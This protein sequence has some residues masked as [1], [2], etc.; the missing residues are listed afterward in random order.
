MKTLRAFAWWGTRGDVMREMAAWMARLAVRGGVSATRLPG[1]RIYK[2]SRDVPRAPLLYEQGIIIVGQGAKR[3]FLGDTVYEYNPDRYL[4]LSVPLPVEC[5]TSASPEEP[6]LALLVDIDLGV[7]KSL[8]EALEEHGDLVPG[9]QGASPGLF[10]AHADLSF[11]QTVCRLLETLQSPLDTE[12]LG[13]G[14]VRELLFR[15]MNGENAASLHA[16]AMKQSNLA[17]IDKALKQI[18]GNYQEPMD[19]QKLAGL[20]NMSVSAFH[21]A[22]K[23]V[24]ASSPIQYIKK[25]RLNKARDLLAFQGLRVNEAATVVGYESATQFSRE[26][27]RYFGNSPVAFVSHPRA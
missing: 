15:V 1:V 18:H 4:V 16:L 13:K 19:V 24:T 27:K 22:F 23:E 11:Q 7:L 21:R 25:I 5:E 6:F 12:V 26:F 17:R 2:A 10:L 9:E 8:V 3:V 20:V 14:L